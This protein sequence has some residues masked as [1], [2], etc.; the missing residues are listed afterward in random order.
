MLQ[1]ASPW[2][3]AGSWLRGGRKKAGSWGCLGTG[4]AGRPEHLPITFPKRGADSG[5]QS[6]RIS[7]RVGT[8]PAWK[9]I[10]RQTLAGGLGVQSAG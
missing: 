5:G 2:S 8:H 3:G 10:G 1:P 7:P 4:E 6:P 9:P